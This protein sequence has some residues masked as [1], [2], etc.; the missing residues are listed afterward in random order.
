[1]KSI[2]VSAVHLASNYKPM[3][4]RMPRPQSYRLIKR[5]PDRVQ[6]TSPESGKAGE[7]NKNPKLKK[8]GLTQAMM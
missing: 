2:T 4:L 7:K 6:T 8:R 3:K 1:M 5:I